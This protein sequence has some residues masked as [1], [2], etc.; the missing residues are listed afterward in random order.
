MAVGVGG[1]TDNIGLSALKIQKDRGFIKV[2]EYMQT[3]VDNIWMETVLIYMWSK[4]RGWCTKETKRTKYQD[5]FLFNVI[6]Q[7]NLVFEE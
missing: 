7:I 5:K 1:N 3:N 2:N 4:L 6:G